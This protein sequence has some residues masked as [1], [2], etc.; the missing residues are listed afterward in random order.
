MIYLV[1]KQNLPSDKYKIITV[2]ESLVFLNKCNTLQYDSETTGKDAHICNILCIQFGSKKYDFQI[3]VDITSTNILLYKDILESKFLIGQNLKFDL[4]FLYKYEIVPTKVYDTMIVEQFLYLGYPASVISCSLKN[5]AQRRLNVDIDKTIRGE[6]I[7]RGLD[8][9]V[10]VYSANDVVYLEDIMLSQLKDVYN[11][12]A[13]KGAKVEC[14]FVPVIAYLEWCGIKLDERKWQTKMNDDVLH[15]TQAK[16]ELD[17]FVISDPKLSKFV[18]QNLQGDLFS[19]YNTDPIC[20]INW[21]S[22]QQVIELAKILGFNTQVKDKKTGEEKDS[23]LE[24]QLKTQKKVNDK[25]LDLYFKYKEYEKVISSFG[26]AHLDAI[27][28]ITGR[29]H[30]VYRQ[31]GASS[32]RMSCGSTQNNTDLAHYK[33]IKECH[34]PNIQQLPHDEV[35]RAAFVA[36]EGNWFCSCDFSAEEARLAG[37]IYQDQVIID[38]FKMGIDSHSYYAKVFFKEQLKDVDVNNIKKKYPHL[39]TKAKGPEFAL[40]FGGGASAIMQ[41]LQCTKEEADQII[42]NYEEGFKGT[43]E[44]AKKGSKF[45]REHGYI[46]ICPITNHRM[47]WWDWDKWREKEDF[48]KSDKWS[49]K[50]YKETYKGKNSITEKQVREH[51]KAASKYDR[52]ARNSPCQGTASIILKSAMTTFFKWILDNHYFNIVKLCALVHDEACIEYPKTILDVDKKLEQIMEETAA[53]YCKSLPIPAC[54]E[55]SDHWVH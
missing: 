10:I 51:F 2:E 32:G 40:S 5:I 45:V 52:M 9:D 39:R 47:Y 12:N 46:T 31:I 23:V 26:Q 4:Q 55:V 8:E 54:A 28:P 38:M 35:T 41:A 29:I 49:W 36:E 37:D 7:W 3:V 30:T 18:T 25:F 34:M 6:I 15:Y 43:A 14:D 24:K 33:G 21:A 50:F 53:V 17:N 22:S 16:K 44:F 48:Y 1:T 27:N 20:T 19:G 13:I 11:R 42:K